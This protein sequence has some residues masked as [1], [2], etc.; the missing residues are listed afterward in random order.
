MKDC[1]FSKAQVLHLAKILKLPTRVILQIND[2]IV[3]SKLDTKNQAVMT[4]FRLTLKRR[5]YIR[6]M[7]NYPELFTG[8]RERL[9][10]RSGG[11]KEPYVF[12]E[13]LEDD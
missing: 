4:E 2:L 13:L 11:I 5:L 6:C 10:T 1:Q 12:N 8:A 9:S 7:N 3:Y